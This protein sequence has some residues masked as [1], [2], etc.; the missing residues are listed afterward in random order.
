[1]INHSGDISSFLNMLEITWNSLFFWRFCFFFEHVWNYIVQ[2]SIKLN[3]ESTCVVHV[4]HY[5]IHYHTNHTV[6]CAQL[7]WHTCH[8]KCELRRN[9]C[10]FP[11]FSRIASW[12]KWQNH[13]HQIFQS[14]VF[15]CV[16]LLKLQSRKKNFW[17]RPLVSGAD[18]RNR[19]W[20]WD[21]WV[22][23][24]DPVKPQ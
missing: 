22:S 14:S 4:I 18:P 20:P 17:S 23:I 24:L 11:W 1:M 2:S 16:F 8:L 5:I 15:L 12:V 9:S 6:I 3:L 19:P 13:I 7:T 21:V 10:R